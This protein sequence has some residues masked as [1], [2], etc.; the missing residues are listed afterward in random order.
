MKPYLI[1]ILSL[2]HL[3]LA[4]PHQ[5]AAQPSITAKV[6]YKGKDVFGMPL[7]GMVKN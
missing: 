5:A 4:G 7:D 2:A 3:L 1:Y 6:K